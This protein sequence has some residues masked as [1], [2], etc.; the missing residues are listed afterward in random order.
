MMSYTESIL[1]FWV[2][3]AVKANAK[4]FSNA[5]SFFCLFNDI[6]ADVLDK[7]FSWKFFSEIFC[8]LEI[9]FQYS[10]MDSRGIRYCVII[11]PGSNETPTTEPL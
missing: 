8:V 5:N 1:V 2:L 9:F 6:H 4:V 10:L 11:L 3:L 7:L